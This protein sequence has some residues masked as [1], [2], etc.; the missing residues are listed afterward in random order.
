MGSIYLIII[1]TKSF[2][3]YILKVS[4]SFRPMSLITLSTVMIIIVWLRFWISMI[5]QVCAE[6]DSIIFRRSFVISHS[7]NFV[8]H[9]KISELSL[10]NYS[11]A[12]SHGDL[13]V[14][15]AFSRGILGWVLNAKELTDTLYFSQVKFFSSTLSCEYAEHLRMPASMFS[16]TTIHMYASFCWGF[17]PFVNEMSSS[18]LADFVVTASIFYEIFSI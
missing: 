2:S 17:H 7:S 14:L 11:N 13:M 6:Y 3:L 15:K 5:D 12:F 4:T 10:A 8:L 1:S 18:L 9:S 16:A